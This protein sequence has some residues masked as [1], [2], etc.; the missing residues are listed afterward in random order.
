MLATLRIRV[1]EEIRTQC[2]LAF[3][4]LPFLLFLLSL[5][6]RKRARPQA[7]DELRG[8]AVAGR[9]SVLHSPSEHR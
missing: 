7:A 5:G 6:W 2:Y 1:L 3:S 8:E 9:V 4:S